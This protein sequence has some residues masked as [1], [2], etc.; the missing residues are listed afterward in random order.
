MGLKILIVDD[1]PFMRFLLRQILEEAGHQIVGEAENGK[2]ALEMYEKLQPDLVT[3]DVVMPEMTGI[4]A[5]KKIRARSPKARCV[6]VTAIDQRDHLLEAMQA[7]ALDYV[8]KPF[9]K[10]RVL[11]ALSRSG[12]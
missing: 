5:L 4:E 10:E 12:C 6:M 9:E 1:A 11:K 2:E 3:L 7:G 8:V